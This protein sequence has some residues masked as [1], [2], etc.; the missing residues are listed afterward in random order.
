[1]MTSRLASSEVR[2]WVHSL[3]KGVKPQVV[4]GF[5]KAYQFN[6]V[7]IHY[8]AGSA[9]AFDAMSVCLPLWLLRILYAERVE[10]IY[11]ENRDGAVGDLAT[12][13]EVTAF[14]FSAVQNGVELGPDWRSV[15]SYTTFTTLFRHNLLPHR[16]ADLDFEPGKLRHYGG[17]NLSVGQTLDLLRP[18]Q[19]EL[20]R[21]ATWSGQVN[22]LTNG[23]D[24]AGFG[25]SDA[26][27]S[28]RDYAVSVQRSLNGDGAVTFGSGTARMLMLPMRD[29]INRLLLPAR[30]EV[31]YGS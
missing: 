14:L 4:M 16:A 25:T 24:E 21:A 8:F 29:R 28:F 31:T 18:L 2:N 20:R 1:M 27:V 3:K 13:A 30:Q 10:L 12:L 9:V 15:Y 6:E 23:H 26:R 22:I 11:G 5:L 17:K 19:V 7:H